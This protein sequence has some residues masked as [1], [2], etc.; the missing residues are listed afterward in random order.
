MTNSTI[1]DSAVRTADQDLVPA[2]TE[3]SQSAPAPKPRG[4]GT[5]ARI[6]SLLKHLA[7]IL[8]GG[9]MIYPLLWMLVSSFRPTE[10]IFREPGLWL[11]EI[12]TANYTEGWN[13][14][15][16]PFGNRARLAQHLLGGQRHEL[17]HSRALGA[18]GAD[19]APEIDERH[20]VALLPALGLV[21]P[22]LFFQGAVKPL[23]YPV[24][25]WRP[26]KSFGHLQSQVFHFIH[27]I[28]RVI[29]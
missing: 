19:D 24:A 29:L 13:A 5:R 2:Q 16:H 7:L 11:S 10:V 26:Y 6:R 4:P 21:T 12:H 18:T 28:G 1:A 8:T 25:L 20:Q 14:L 3:G 23:Y 27:K 15:Q 17:Q 22:G 9:V